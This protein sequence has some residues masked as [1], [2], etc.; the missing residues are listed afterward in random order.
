M[1]HS[2]TDMFNPYLNAKNMAFKFEKLRVWQYSFD[3][4]EKI[5]VVANDFPEKGRYN[6]NI[7]TK[8]CR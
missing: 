7:P 3:L 1:G 4:A 8:R 2:H 6:L 5:V